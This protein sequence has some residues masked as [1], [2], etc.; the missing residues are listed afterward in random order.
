MD[1]R[2]GATVITL[3]HIVVEGLP[4]AK[5]SLGQESRWMQQ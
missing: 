4:C 3:C 2:L 5:K 1:T